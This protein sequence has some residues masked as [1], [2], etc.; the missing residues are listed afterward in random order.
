MNI[1]SSS[2]IS[3]SPGPAAGVAPVPAE[4]TAAQSRPVKTAAKE[5][6]PAAEAAA[7]KAAEAAAAQ[8]NPEEL[9]SSVDAIN[10]FLKVN[11]EVQFSIDDT[12]GKSVIKVIDTESKKILRQFPSQQ[13]LE[14]GKDLQGQGLKGL[15]IDNKA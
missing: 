6:A 7:K 4:T 2:S 11:S 5:A 15:L 8:V 12:S 14:V 13:A 1:N 10:R 9:K 3:N